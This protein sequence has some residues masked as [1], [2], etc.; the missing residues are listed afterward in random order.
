MI[1][2]YGASPAMAGSSPKAQW[3]KDQW[4]H[5]KNCGSP[6][7]VEVL[8][9]L[10]IGAPTVT[11]C[12]GEQCWGASRVFW[13]Q[14]LRMRRRYHGNY[15]DRNNTNKGGADSEGGS[16]FSDCRARHSL[17]G[18]RPGAHQGSSLWCL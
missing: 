2:A 1:N 12:S 10:K 5:E 7:H 9:T 3:W 15:K 13:G 16:R 11:G 17:A 8:D 4:V 14:M 6:Y 18:P